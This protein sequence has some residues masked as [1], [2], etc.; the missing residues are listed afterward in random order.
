M[1]DAQDGKCMY[2]FFP[3]PR[4]V[5]NMKDR[6]YRR[7]W[8]VV[9]RTETIKISSMTSF[10]WVWCHLQQH[11][12]T[13]AARRAIYLSEWY[14]QPLNEHESVS[15]PKKYYYSHLNQRSLQGRCGVK[16]SISANEKP[17]YIDLWNNAFEWRSPKEI[18]RMMNIFTFHFIHS[19]FCEGLWLTRL[20]WVR[21][22]KPLVL[23]AS[24]IKSFCIWSTHS[25][26][27]RTHP[28][29]PN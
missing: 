13:G 9:P 6:L 20:T 19:F 28:H 18:W 25:L 24:V 22:C 21:L 23:S 3:P 27:L 8:D 12:D 10:C 29:T 15:P 1:S 17:L 26:I 11:T 5:T 2:W 4:V 14:N 16:C 7:I